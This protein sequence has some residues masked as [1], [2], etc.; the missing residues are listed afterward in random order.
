MPTNNSIDLAK[1]K[2]TLSDDLVRWAL[3][4]GRVLIIIVE[5]VAFSAF[6][7]RFV[8]DRE[9]VDLNDKIKGEQAIVASLKDR[10]AEY[11]NLQERIARVKNITTTGN[12]KLKLLN[13]IV[14]STPQQI[15]YG[16]ILAEDNKLLLTI[17]VSSVPE[18]SIYIDYLQKYDQIESVIITGIDNSSGVSFVK[19]DLEAKLKG[20]PN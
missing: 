15:T 14:A 13:D 4:F 8:L 20:G 5:I 17:N 7:Y 19:V 16:S 2:S 12:T 10:E 3:G 9:L 11:R 18:L 1:G 6:I